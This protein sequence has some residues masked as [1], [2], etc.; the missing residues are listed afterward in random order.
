MGLK[1]LTGSNDG[2]KGRGLLI[3]FAMVGNVQQRKRMRMERIE[4]WSNNG[5]FSRDR[6][7]TLRFS[8][9]KLS[10]E[11]IVDEVVL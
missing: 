3:G 2:I 9:W 5:R 4:R 1:R 7:T 8:M 10:T 6:I 11:A